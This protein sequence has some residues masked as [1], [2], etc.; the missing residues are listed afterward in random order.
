MRPGEPVDL[1]LTPHS[2]GFAS[3]L[4]HEIQKH[5]PGGGGERRDRPG[6]AR[7][8]YNESYVVAELTFDELVKFALPLTQWW[9][10]H[11]CRGE[12]IAT[13]LADPSVQATIATKIKK[14]GRASLGKGEINPDLLWLMRIVGRI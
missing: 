5:I 8:A 2:E 14:T 9:R 7:I 11:L 1:L 10:K 13:Q 3:E 6:E 12:T 4:G